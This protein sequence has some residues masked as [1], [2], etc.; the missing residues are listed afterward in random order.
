VNPEPLNAVVI[1]II[2]RNID[3]T[4]KKYIDCSLK[5]IAIDGSLSQN[6]AGLAGLVCTGPAFICDKRSI[7]RVWFSPGIY[8][9]SG[10]FPFPFILA[11]SRH[12]YLRVFTGIFECIGLDSPCRFSGTLYGII[13]SSLVQSREKT[14][15]LSGNDSVV[16]GGTGIF[17]FLSILRISLGII[18]ILPV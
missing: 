1:K 3:C 5:R 9:R 10:S 2:L 8:C 18:G 16:M 11:G 13:R 14:S 15:P 17:A 4:K 7:C 6:R 12:A